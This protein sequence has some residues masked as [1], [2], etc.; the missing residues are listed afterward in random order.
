MSIVDEDT[1]TAHVPCGPDPEPFLDS[2]RTFVDAGYDHVYFHQVGD[3]QEGFLDF[4][5]REL[6]PVLRHR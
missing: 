6:E 5:Q 3:D 2:V 4:W 1:A